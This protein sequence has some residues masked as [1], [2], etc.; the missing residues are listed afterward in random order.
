MFVVALVASMP[1][2]ALMLWIGRLHSLRLGL[3]VATLG[4]GL[5]MYPHEAALLFGRAAQGLALSLLWFN[6]V[7]YG[8][9]HCLD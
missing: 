5:A 4:C 3:V 7:P 1:C 6:V 2:Y 8:L 9:N